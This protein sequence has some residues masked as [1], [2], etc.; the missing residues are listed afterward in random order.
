MSR[1]KFGEIFQQLKNEML[2]PKRQIRVN[3][4]TFGPGVNFGKGVSFSGVDFIEH[5]GKDIA[6]E[7]QADGV[8]VIKG[9]YND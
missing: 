6:A 2:T 7:E 4:I 3:G 8:L 1:Y 5:Q 9:I